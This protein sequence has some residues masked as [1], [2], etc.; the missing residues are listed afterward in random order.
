MSYD[1]T[2]QPTPEFEP[3]PLPGETPSPTV[4]VHPQSVYERARATGAHYAAQDEL[5]MRKLQEITPRLQRPLPSAPI[6]PTKEPNMSALVRPQKDVP[7]GYIKPLKDYGNPKTS[8][9]WEDMTREQRESALAN[10]TD[11][12]RTKTAPAPE[13]TS[14]EKNVVEPSNPGRPFT[15]LD[16]ARMMGSMKKPKTGVDVEGENATGLELP[17]KKVRKPA[18]P[19]AIKRAA[20]SVANSHFEKFDTSGT[21]IKEAH[22]SALGY[23]KKNFTENGTNEEVESLVKSNYPHMLPKEMQTPRTDTAFA[24]RVAPKTAKSGAAVAKFASN[25]LSA[26]SR[27]KSTKADRNTAFTEGQGK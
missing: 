15:G 4:G 19:A 27:S 13:V 25:P 23:F 7:V 6:T 14:I 26:F 24:P 10:S 12:P 5:A 21:D 22:G 20:E 17:A 11:S 2:R 3:D 8:V 18:L 1:L 9:K 16:W